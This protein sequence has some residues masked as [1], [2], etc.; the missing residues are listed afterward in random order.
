M[1]S[2]KDHREA[3]VLLAVGCAG[4]AIVWG[5]LARAGMPELGVAAFVTIALVVASRGLFRS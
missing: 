4:A 3:F 5:A 1:S 2:A